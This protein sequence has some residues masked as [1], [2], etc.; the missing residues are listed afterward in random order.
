MNTFQN[1]VNQN[2]LLY[3]LVKLSIGFK[4]RAQGDNLDFATDQVKIL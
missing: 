1:T 4:E 3:I 2:L